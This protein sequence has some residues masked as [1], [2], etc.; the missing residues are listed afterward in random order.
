M[1]DIILLIFIVI[2]VIAITLIIMYNRFI[3]LNIRCNNAWSGI[4]NQLKR[5]NDLIPNLVNVTKGYAKY[6]S[7]TL[8]KIIEARS[9]SISEKAKQSEEIS[10]N[11]NKL[12]ALGESYPD[13]KANQLFLN[14]QIELTGTEDKIAYARQFYNDCVQY[15]NTTIMM[16]PNNIFAK[17]L[18]YKEREYFKVS[19]EEKENVSVKL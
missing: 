16:F 10:K 11:V 8:E 2:A 7:E 14:L 9:G 19:D 17:M 18:K 5:R 6:E 13:L 15:F 3:K 4:D 12:L 1:Q